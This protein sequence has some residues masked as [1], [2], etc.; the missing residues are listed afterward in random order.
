MRSP[1][2]IRRA[3]PEHVSRKLDHEGLAGEYSY[4]RFVGMLVCSNAYC[5]EAVAVAG[6]FESRE[7]HHWDEEEGDLTYTDTQYFPR[8]FRPAPRMIEAP[9]S[10]NKDAKQHLT[11]A[12]ELFWADAGACANRLRIVVE[13]LLDQMGIPREGPKG[14]KDRARLDLADRIT[15]LAAAKPGHEDALSALRYVGNNGSHEGEADFEDL[16]DCFELLENAMVELL[17]ERQAKLA[18]KA[19]RIIEAKGRGSR[20]AP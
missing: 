12:F 10:L 14:R 9:T 6:D 8:L 5:G 11:K 18:E 3:E 2:D 4:G 16:L 17:E 20:A 1:D 15:L 19:R 13:Y 7:H